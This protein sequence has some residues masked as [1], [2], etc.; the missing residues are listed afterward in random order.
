MKT[1]EKQISES[2]KAYQTAKNF[3]I[4]SWLDGEVE[5][6]S[7]NTVMEDSYMWMQPTKNSFQNWKNHTCFKTIQEWNNEGFK[8]LKGSH[9]FKFAK[10][11]FSITEDLGFNFE[12]EL[13]Y[14]FSN[15]QTIK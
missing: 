2:E 7:F 6:D 11:D 9:G 14:K 10:V 15:L 3:S 13:I 1:I 5:S 12:T 8:I 4:S